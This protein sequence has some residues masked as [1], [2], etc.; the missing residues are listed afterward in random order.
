M[1]IA[2]DTPDGVA[3]LMLSVMTVDSHRFVSV[4]VGTGLL[5][6]VVEEEIRALSSTVATAV[7]RMGFRGWF[8]IDF[9]VDARGGCS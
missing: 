1:R 4:D 9:I 3:E 5:P 2:D 8:G 7:R 6:A